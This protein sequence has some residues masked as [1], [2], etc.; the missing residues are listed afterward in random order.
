MS[1]INDQD[2]GPCSKIPHCMPNFVAYPA[3]TA[4]Q[5]RTSCSI[6]ATNVYK[7]KNECLEL[8]Q[9]TNDCRPLRKTKKVDE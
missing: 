5:G 7:I 9:I 2:I 8:E 6:P 1:V 4:L 3:D